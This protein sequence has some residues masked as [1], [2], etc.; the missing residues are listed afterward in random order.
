MGSTLL[1]FI[2]FRNVRLK[3]YCYRLR[4]MSEE[5]DRIKSSIQSAD[6]W[7]K[8]LNRNK[9]KYQSRIKNLT[10]MQNNLKVVFDQWVLDIR[11]MESHILKLYEKI[12]IDKNRFSVYTV[13]E[14]EN[15]QHRR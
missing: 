11:R 12:G 1:D 7:I 9:P 6:A 5:A 3:I 14:V 15:D 10:A 8:V 2:L 13:D 4:S